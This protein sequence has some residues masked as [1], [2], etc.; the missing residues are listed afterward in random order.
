M[1]E[2][3]AA[4]RELLAAAE[5]AL[6]EGYVEGRH[7]VAAAVRTGAGRIVTGLNLEASTNRAAVCAEAIAIGRAVC[8]GAR[9]FDAIVAV[10]Y[11]ATGGAAQVCSPC[12]VCR[13]LIAD[14]APEATVLVWD[15]TLQRSTLS[16][17]L[18]ASWGWD[19]V[20]P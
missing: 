19:G 14:Y 7:D 4:D 16:E 3:T 1:E 6:A 12:G 9:G 8:E 5:A 10:W 18:P 17:L 11:P 20:R 15:G 2:P 13:E